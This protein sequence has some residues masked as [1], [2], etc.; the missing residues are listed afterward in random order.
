[1]PTWSDITLPV[2]DGVKGVGR[3]AL[4][5]T[6]NLMR[7]A[8]TCPLEGRHAAVAAWLR[9]LT[10]E[11]VEVLNPKDPALRSMVF[12]MWKRAHVRI[13][14]DELVSLS[15]AA[16]AKAYRLFREWYGMTPKAFILASRLELAEALLLQ[17]L[18]I[19]EVSWRCGWENPTTFARCWQR[20]H[21]QR[22]SDFSSQPAPRRKR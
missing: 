10:S 4:H 11:R 13:T 2:R 3:T 20:C 14:P 22:P 9:Q 7:A 21:G 19:A 12:A 6:R 8:M 1:M 5:P 15:G 17:G 18:P 16:R